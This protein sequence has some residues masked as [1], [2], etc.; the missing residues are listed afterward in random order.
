M[1]WQP[2]KGKLSMIE[3]MG[4]QIGNYRLLRLLGQGA[5]ADVYAL[6]EWF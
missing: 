4:R 3:R 2:V 1:T 6:C 5:F